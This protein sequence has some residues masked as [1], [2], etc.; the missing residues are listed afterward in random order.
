MLEIDLFK[1]KNGAV[2]SY[3]VKE[4]LGGLHVKMDRMEKSLGD[5]RERFAIAETKLK[6]HRRLFYAIF[7]CLAGLLYLILQLTGVI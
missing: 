3:S 4:L 2:V 7:S 5:G 6:I 1:K